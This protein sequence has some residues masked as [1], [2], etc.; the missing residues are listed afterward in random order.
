M[1]IL[2][3]IETNIIGLVV[4]WGEGKERRLKTG[5]LP[6]LM[7]AVH[8]WR[9]G[10]RVSGPLNKDLHSERFLNHGWLFNIK[11]QA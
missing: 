5:Q 4:R 6:F 10:G 7:P 8:T 9:A 3:P 1:Y 11:K 2:C